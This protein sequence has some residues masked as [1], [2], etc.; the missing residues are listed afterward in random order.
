M[1][2]IS[3]FKLVSTALTTLSG[4]EFAADA[5]RSA[6]SEPLPDLFIVYSRITS[7][8]ANYFDNKAQL[9]FVT[10]QLSIFSRDGLDDLPD[11][12]TAMQNQGFS[13]STET[14]LPYNDETRHYGVSREYTIHLELP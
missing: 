9:R 11:T 6:L 13:V 7:P 10:M 2:T 12:D 4:V 14:D 1:T 5:N 8:I 3:P